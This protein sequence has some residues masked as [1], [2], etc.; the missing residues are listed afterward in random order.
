MPESVSIT[1]TCFLERMTRVLELFNAQR[2]NEQAA[3][4]KELQLWANLFQAVEK[5]LKSNLAA[6]PSHTNRRCES[7][8]MGD[9]ARAA[10]F[11]NGDHGDHDD[12]ET[13]KSEGTM[14]ET[15]SPGLR[16]PPGLHRSNVIP[17]KL[18]QTLDPEWQKLVRSDGKRRRQQDRR[19]RNKRC[20]T[21]GAHPDLRWPS[22]QHG[23]CE[24]RL[25]QAWQRTHGGACDYMW[26]TLPQPYV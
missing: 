23:L 9:D 6:E 17:K 11:R 1:Y 24:Q 18:W 4:D 14:L 3:R 13:M 21:A 5:A 7:L 8:V 19:A 25:P 10:D 22:Q 16:V 2:M 12:R 15:A 20:T 26:M